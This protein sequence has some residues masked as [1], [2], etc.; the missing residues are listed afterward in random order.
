MM[1]RG[2]NLP[3]VSV[4]SRKVSAMPGAEHESPA[5]LA[6]LDSGLVAWLLT[7]IFRVKL[8]DYHHG[9]THATDVRVLVPRTYH[10]DSTLLAWTRAG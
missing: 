5:T 1:T 3:E 9:R 4:R 6:K 2:T 10:A 8:P 7:N